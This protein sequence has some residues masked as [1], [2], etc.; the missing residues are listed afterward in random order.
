M[1]DSSPTIKTQDARPSGFSSAE[2]LV[3]YLDMNVWIKL[4]QGVAGKSRAWES[5]FGRLEQAVRSGKVL[6]PLSSAHYMELWNRGKE[7]SRTDV[8]R[9]MAS[10]SSYRT[11]R[12]LHEVQILEIRAEIARRITGIVNPLG[13]EKV[14]G[15]GVNHAFASQHGRLRFVSYAATE[16][17]P[18]GA[19]VEAPEGWENFQ[20]SEQWEWFQLSGPQ[21]LI[22]SV[23]FDRTPEHRL[24]AEFAD[25]ENTLRHHL[26]Q[27][28]EMWKRRSDVVLGQ[29]FMR[30]L[31]TINDVAAER[32]STYTGSSFSMDQ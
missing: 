24:G 32:V 22:D 13:R 16:N 9:M 8:A 25:E 15:V 3:L 5:R 18:E 10:L 30:L 14:I 26:S 17:T 27:D 6:I 29:E 23:G 31:E 7:A 12:A 2:Q 28:K 20:R 4:A 11:L 1:N 19:G 21:Q